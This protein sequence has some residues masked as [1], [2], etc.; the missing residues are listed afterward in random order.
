MPVERAA[1]SAAL[2][3]LLSMTLGLELNDTCASA[4]VM[5]P[6]CCAVPAAD[7][8]GAAAVGALCSILPRRR[9]VRLLRPL[10]RDGEQALHLLQGAA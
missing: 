1:Q 7:C 5:L 10:V 2:R 8:G 9:G 6:V 3:T 4:V